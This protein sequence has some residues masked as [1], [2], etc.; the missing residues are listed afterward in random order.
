MERRGSQCEYG[1]LGLFMVD[2][3]V[4][5]IL[6]YGVYSL[7]LGLLVLILRRG[8]VKRLAAVFVYLTSL[9]AID[10]L[11]RELV[12]HYYG[13]QSNQY[14]Y[15]YW[16]TNALLQLA[17]LLLV[18]SFFRAVFAQQKRWWDVLKLALPMVFVLVAAISLFSIWRNYS[19]V[20]KFEFITE[21]EQYLYF[22]CL[23]LNTLLFIMMQYVESPDEVLPLLVCGLGLQFAG[24]AASM[25][26]VVLAPGRAYAQVLMSHLEPLCTFGMLLVWLYAVT[27]APSVVRER[28]PR[29]IEQPVAA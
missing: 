3:L 28:R 13:W 18:C 20:A 15:F 29:A 19:R 22:T 17:A 23:I 6:R 1:F 24:P 16:L 9:A 27:R 12:L 4:G 21:F 14:A 11:G 26:L 2:A 25:A 7:E 10:A 5:Y 8:Q